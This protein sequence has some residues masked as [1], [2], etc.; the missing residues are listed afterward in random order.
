MEKSWLQIDLCEC[1][2]RLSIQHHHDRWS[3]RSLN[4][5]LIFAILIATSSGVRHVSVNLSSLHKRFYDRRTEKVVQA[6]GDR[7]ESR[8]THTPDVMNE[9]FLGSVWTLWI[10][11]ITV[12]SI[13]YRWVLPD[14]FKLCVIRR[15][16][17]RR[18]IFWGG[19]DVVRPSTCSNRQRINT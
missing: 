5:L 11:G 19:G 1:I 13:D 9:D 15:L 6:G 16:N 18:S 8:S 3:K 4:I 7:R 17:F 14:P 12:P 2:N 10:N